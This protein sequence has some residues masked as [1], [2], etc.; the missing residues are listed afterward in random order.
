LLEIQGLSCTRGDTTL[1]RDL[2]FALDAGGSAHVQGPNGAGKTTLLRALCGL[3]R[4][5][6]GKVLW[7]QTEIGALAEEYRANLLHIGHL[8]GLHGELS[9]DE[10]LRYD[11][12]LDSPD[13]ASVLTA[14]ADFGL[15]RRAHLP[16]KLLSQG[17]KRRVALARLAL[18]RRTLWILDEPFAALDVAAVKHLDGIIEQHLER[19]GM[20]VLTA[21]HALTFRAASLSPVRLG[22]A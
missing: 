3:T 15:A 18:A 17:Q 13:K 9:A 7:K 1:F 5:A 12:C 4:P 11:T 14:L 10:N 2:S 20:L 16:V 6:D 19:G 8:N 22:A 21:H